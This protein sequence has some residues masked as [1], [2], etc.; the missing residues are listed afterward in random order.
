MTPAPSFPSL[1]MRRLRRHDWSRRLVSESTLSPNDFI[2][3]IFL[4]DGKNERQPVPSM[5][6]VERFSV[7]PVTKTL[8]REVR[9]E[10][11]LY[12]TEPFSRT[13]TMIVST[14]PYAPEPCR[15]LTPTVP[16]APQR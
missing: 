2:W 4:I 14:V 9:A 13:D 8:K 1:R 6:G 11:P 5:P 3:P 10:D 12:F 7:D 15:D 16:S